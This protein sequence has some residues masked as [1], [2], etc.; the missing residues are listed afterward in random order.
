MAAALLAG[1]AGWRLAV[2]ALCLAAPAASLTSS[3]PVCSY[4]LIKDSAAGSAGAAAGAAAAAAAGAPDAA[5]APTASV[6]LPP[7]A[8][9]SG[10]K[11]VLGLSMDDAVRAA[12]VLLLLWALLALWGLKGE[13][14]QLKEMLQAMQRKQ[15]EL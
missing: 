7:A 15:C 12:M 6:D 1:T 5:A 3:P 10:R 4:T 11:L 13:V 9:P 14:R 2:S 8:E